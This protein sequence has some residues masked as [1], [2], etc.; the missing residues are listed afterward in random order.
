[1]SQ[2][3]INKLAVALAIERIVIL[4]DKQLP[5]FWRKTPSNL[6]YRLRVITGWRIKGYRDR[7]TGLIHF[8]RML[9]KQKNK[10][11]KKKTD[12]CLIQSTKETQVLN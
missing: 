2:L 5:P 10:Q 6:A 12:K 1:M 9:P 11:K 8:Q 4:E 3:L 7:E